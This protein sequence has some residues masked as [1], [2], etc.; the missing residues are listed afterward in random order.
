LPVLEMGDEN[1]YYPR[2]E[3]SSLEMFF[4]ANKMLPKLLS[5]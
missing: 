1:E 4:N 3:G 2:I 5:P